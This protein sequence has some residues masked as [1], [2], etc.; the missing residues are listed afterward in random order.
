MKPSSNIYGLHE[1][2]QLWEDLGNWHSSLRKKARMYVTQRYKWDPNNR[3]EVNTAIAKDLLGD[4]RAFLR[5]SIDE[6][7]SHI[8]HAHLP[9][10]NLFSGTY[11]QLGTSCTLGTDYRFLL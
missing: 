11:Q 5:D 1:A 6:Q 4:C 9:V 10:S 8:V 2:L 7:V 3:Q